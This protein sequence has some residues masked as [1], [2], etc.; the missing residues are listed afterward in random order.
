MFTAFKSR[1]IPPLSMYA[2]D[3][4]YGREDIKLRSEWLET[5]VM[6]PWESLKSPESECP[7]WYHGSE[8]HRKPA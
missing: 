4:W 5:S 8:S 7:G 3:L 6:K 1:E 2:K